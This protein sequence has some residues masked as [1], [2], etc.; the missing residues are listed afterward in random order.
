MCIFSGPVQSVSNTR[1]FGRTFSASQET[2]HYARQVI[3]YQMKFAADNP[4]AM[5]LPIPIIGADENAVEFID[6]S[7]CADF[8]EKLD[9][10]FPNLSKS[11][12]ADSFGRRGMGSDTLEV[13]R[14]GKF[15]ASYVPSI[16]DFKRLDQRFTLPRNTWDKIPAYADYGFVVF[17][18]NT[19][20]PPITTGFQM[21]TPA[22]AS[23]AGYGKD[24]GDARPSHI[25]RRS[26]QSARTSEGEV[27]DVHPMAFS[28][29]SRF[30][31]GIFFPTVHIHDGEVHPTEMFDHALYIQSHHE[32][33]SEALGQV[34]GQWRKSESKL[35]GEIGPS[36][37]IDALD[38][39]YKATLRGELNNIDVILRA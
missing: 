37:V 18:L 20:A 1:I 22:G 6:L 9:A 19:D 24:I 35:G 29:P 17:K 15:D 23:R 25:I 13:H 32:K 26:R 39:G 34:G 38:F 4:L 8:F 31:N 28:F 7:R 27:Q 12:G 2:K 33:L 14:V 16:N 3:V 30:P 36:T 11:L 10:K 5:I 21:P